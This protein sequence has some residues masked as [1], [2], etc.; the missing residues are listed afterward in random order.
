MRSVWL[1]IF[2]CACLIT[3]AG[4]RK[5]QETITPETPQTTTAPTLTLLLPT[6][7]SMVT[8]TQLPI[9]TAA[10][11]TTASPLAP[12]PS[13]QPFLPVDLPSIGADNISQLQLL[14]TLPVQEIYQLA[15]SV[16]GNKLVT[17][18]EPWDDRFNDYLQVWNLQD[19]I[20]LLDIQ[21]LDS[22]AQAFFSAD[23]S[24]V[25]VFF[26][27]KGLDVYDLNQGD[28]VRTIPL[29][30][31]Q[32]G[33]LPD[34]TTVALA[35]YQDFGDSSFVRLVD[36]NTEQEILNFSEPGMVMTLKLSPD[37]SLLA[38][39]SQVGNHYRI[40]VREIPSLHLVTDLIDF[41]SELVFSHDNSLAA[42][43]KNG[44]VTL[45]STP[46]MT[47]KASYGFSDPLTDPIPTDFSWSEGSQLLALEDRYTIRF[48]VAE[49]G[50]ELLSLP[51]TCDV[52]FNPNTTVIVTW[53]YQG[54]L[55]IWG[56][57]SEN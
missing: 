50:K 5:T 40:T 19:G 51:D 49:T 31:D 1:I 6:P 8:T 47:W 37:R 54:E 22:P 11:I 43:S 39:G 27:G 36:L 34:V 18:S 4:C 29:D 52:R 16:S 45:F 20:Q 48:L 55:K 13:P 33:F 12:S 24:Q 41:Y 7:T 38:V 44:Q 2:I 23:E 53:C 17:L 14:A 57:T 30:D 9:E 42:I 32:L 10:P 15:F 3:L 28:I 56:I 46:W 35:R 21:K 25:Y 26:V